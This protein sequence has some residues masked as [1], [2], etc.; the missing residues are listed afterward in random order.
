MDKRQLVEVAA[1]HSSLTKRQLGEAVDVIFATI[2]DAL[3]S[4]DSVI[5]KSFGRF[6]TWKRRQQIQ[7]FHGHTHQVEER[8]PVFRA[9][10]ALRRALKERGS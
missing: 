3:S 7:G 10:K 5:L 8:R 4:G 1:R 2:T 9:S 6:S